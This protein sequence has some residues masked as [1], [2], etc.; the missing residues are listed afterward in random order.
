MFEYFERPNRVQLICLY[1]KCIFIISEHGKATYLQLQHCSIPGFF[2]LNIS[3]GYIVINMGFSS[4]L[5]LILVNGQW[6]IRSLLI[7]PFFIFLYVVLF[8]EELQVEFSGREVNICCIAIIAILTGNVSD[9]GGIW[10][11]QRRDG[12]SMETVFVLLFLCFFSV[13]TLKA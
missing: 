1:F 6:R 5:T 2:Y 4:Q 11:R 13:E 8:L 3:I 9:R 7:I 10:G 12:N